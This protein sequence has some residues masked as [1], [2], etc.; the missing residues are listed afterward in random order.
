MKQAVIQTKNLCKTYQLG[1]QEIPVL[2]SISLTI[3]KGEFV[4]VMGP[5]GSGKSTLL[6]ILGGLEHASSG[7]VEINGVDMSAL[8]DSEQSLMRRQKIGFVFQAYNL[9]PNLTVE[10]NI[11]LPL[12]LDKRGAREI[13][14]KLEAILEVVGLKDHRKHTPKELSGGQQQRVSIAR[15]VIT[16]PDILFADEPIGNLDSKT[17]TEILKLLQAI[18]QNKGTTIVMVTHSEESAT[19]GNRVIRLRDGEIVA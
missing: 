7:L 19:Y 11:I 1:S 12:E 16:D 3:P 4:S 2:R 17:G 18:N 5:S 10:E 6:Y 13:T 14:P 8:K 15:A 9:I